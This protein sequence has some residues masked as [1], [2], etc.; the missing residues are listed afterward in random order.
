[1][2]SLKRASTIAEIRTMLAER[3]GVS[4]DTRAQLLS[5][6]ISGVQDV[7]Y[8]KAEYRAAKATALRAWIEFLQAVRRGEAPADNVVPISRAA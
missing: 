4:E 3:L 1:M 2:I 7:N 8:D 6:G 5:H